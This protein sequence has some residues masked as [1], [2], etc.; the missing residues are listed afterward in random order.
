MVDI[1]DCS[2][3]L[4]EWEIV[5]ASCETGDSSSYSID[6]MGTF[7]W[8]CLV[9]LAVVEML[10]VWDST[11]GAGL[12][13]R[14]ETI[15]SYLDTTN[16]VWPSR[17]QT[18]HTWHWSCQQRY[19][20]TSKYTLYLFS[21]TTLPVWKHGILILACGKKLCVK[22]SHVTLSCLFET[23]I[24][25]LASSFLCSWGWLLNGSPCPVPPKC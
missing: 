7:N 8:H 25:R 16:Q 15:R 19:S 6:V 4:M 23:G 12:W 14:L 24:K 5:S 10:A 17:L 20:P 1:Q 2:V 9:R 18:P 11:L 13:I 3:T 22:Q 21:E